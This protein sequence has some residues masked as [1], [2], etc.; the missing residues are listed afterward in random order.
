MTAY[1]LGALVFIIAMVVFIVQNDT[2]VFVQF[3][4]W[5][6]SEVSLAVVVIISACLGALIAFLLYSYKAFRTGQ[7][8]R[9]VQKANQK[10]EEELRVLRASKASTEI[11]SENDSSLSN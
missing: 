4:N 1:L 3:I 11:N 8:L 9:K 10:Y 7:K 2:H 6:S 5:R